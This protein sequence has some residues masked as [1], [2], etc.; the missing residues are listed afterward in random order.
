MTSETTMH[1][2]N[3]ESIARDLRCMLGSEVV[4]KVKEPMALHT[5]FGVGGPAD[6]YVVPRTASDVFNLLQYCD[7]NGVRVTVIG[8]GTNLLVRDGGVEGVII[9]FGGSG[10]NHVC[11]RENIIECEAGVKLSSV[12]GIAS[13]HGLGGIEFLDGIPGTVGGAIRMNAGAFGGTIFDRI[14]QVDF[15][16]LKGKEGT[17][18]R[19]ELN[20]GYRGCNFF[21]ENVVYRVTFECLFGDPRL[22]QEKVRQYRDQRCKTQPLGKSAGCIFKNPVGIPA[23]KLIDDLGLKGLR[24]GGAVISNKH[25]NFIINEGNAKAVDILRLIDLV[26]ERVWAAT[27]IELELEIEVIG[28]E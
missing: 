22:I 17:R 20:P 24:V 13:Q 12:V 3:L 5:S 1:E 14:V 6:V 26:R 10:L 25:A 15:F 11:V 4:I 16:S 2:T 23:G 19:A 27:G 21:R 8:N 28:H 18:R 9:Q 7:R